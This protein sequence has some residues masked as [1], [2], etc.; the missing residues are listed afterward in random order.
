MTELL[1]DPDAGLLVPEWAHTP[2]RD[3]H[4]AAIVVW[5]PGR[6]GLLWD[7]WL[8]PADGDCRRAHV[9][10]HLRWDGVTEWDGDD[11]DLVDASLDPA[12]YRLV[13]RRLDP[14]RSVRSTWEHA[15]GCRV[16]VVQEH[17]ARRRRAR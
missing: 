5:L 14:G 6:P 3:R 17:R 10:S 7:P 12:A 4:G 13:G 11:W 1:R 16:A 8:A 2:Q 15:D 9:A